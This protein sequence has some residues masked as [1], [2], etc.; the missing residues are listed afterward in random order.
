MGPVLLGGTCEVGFGGLPCYSLAPMEIV[1]HRYV[2]T[3]D[4]IDKMYPPAT[5]HV[6][7]D[8]LVSV[9]GEAVRLPLDELEEV[10]SALRGFHALMWAD[11]KDAE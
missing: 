2:H 4:P 6:D 10:L 8:G 1:T 3:W 9:K 5:W 11:A 7:P